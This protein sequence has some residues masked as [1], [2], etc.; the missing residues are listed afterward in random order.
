MTR[1]DIFDKI[2]ILIHTQ[3]TKMNF[4]L[5]Y[6]GLE[7]PH[8]F[9]FDEIHYYSNMYV[10]QQNIGFV[11]LNKKQLQKRI[12]ELIIMNFNDKSKFKK[13]KP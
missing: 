12:L 9:F 8:Q 5:V 6:P 7:F 10:F 4:Q 3:K 1:S 2:D 11:G 13:L